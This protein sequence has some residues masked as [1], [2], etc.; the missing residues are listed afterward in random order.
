MKIHRG[1]SQSRT[2]RLEDRFEVVRGKLLCLKPQQGDDRYAQ[3]VRAL[4]EPR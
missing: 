2:E 4:K 1:T 3:G